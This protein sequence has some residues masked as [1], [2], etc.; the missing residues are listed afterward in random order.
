[1]T[2]GRAKVLGAI[3]AVLAASLWMLVSRFRDAPC[4]GAIFF[5][6]HPP[7][8]G[9]G[10]YVIDV[11]LDR[12]DK[13]CEIELGLPLTGQPDKSRC[14]MTLELKTQGER[15]ATQLVGFA[16]GAAPEQVA[17]S[18]RKGNEVLY[19]TKLEPSYSPYSVEREPGGRFCGDR[20]F[21][22]PACIRGTSE[23]WPFVTNC[24]GPEDCNRG[25][26]C[27]VDPEWGADY[28]SSTA[29]ECTSSSRCLS[30]MAQLA[31]HEDAHCPSEMKCTHAPFADQ[32]RG[33]LSVCR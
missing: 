31:C 1:M 20:A 28:G 22:Q 9:Q 26:V 14:P 5:E 2:P 18:V 24:D 29:T 3:A 17:L 23:C 6:F 15:A 33:A 13:R 8:S 30:R 21:V 10:R 27:C 7:L 12:G 16:V 25:R 19:E 11:D 4:S 32:F